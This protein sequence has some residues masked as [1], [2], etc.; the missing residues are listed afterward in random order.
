MFCRA[1]VNHL[2]VHAG[3]TMV[4]ALLGSTAY[5]LRCFRRLPPGLGLHQRHGWSAWRSKAGLNHLLQLAA[6]STRTLAVRHE[7]RT[8]L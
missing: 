1:F 5:A 3:V 2:N 8:V 7:H 4:A 6:V